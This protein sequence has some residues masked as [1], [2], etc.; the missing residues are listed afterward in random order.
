VHDNASGGGRRVAGHGEAPHVIRGVRRGPAQVLWYVLRIDELGQE[1]KVVGLADDP[2]L[3]DD[4]FAEKGLDQREEHG[5]DGRGVNDDN[6]VHHLRVQ[7]LDE[8]VALVEDAEEGAEGVAG[9]QPLQVDDRGEAPDVLVVLKP[10]AP[11][12]QHAGSP[13]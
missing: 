4:A 2:D 13:A 1:W 12:H 11:G 7:R 3:R 5:E 8:L 6:L 10:E 9:A